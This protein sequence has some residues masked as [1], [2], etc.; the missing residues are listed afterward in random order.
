[1]RSNRWD[2]K[3]V[4]GDEAI[5]ASVS[6]SWYRHPDTLEELE[7]NTLYLL[8]DSESNRAVW[9]EN[10]EDH[11]AFVS[12]DG[13]KQERWYRHPDSI[14][15]SNEPAIYVS[16]SE[17][18]E[19]KK[20]LTIWHENP[21]RRCVF[22]S[23]DGEQV[24]WYRPPD[25]PEPNWPTVYVSEDSQGNPTIWHENPKHRG[26]FV[27]EDGE[28]VYD[29]E[30]KKFIQIYERRYKTSTWICRR[31]RLHGQFYFLSRFA[32]EAFEGSVLESDE[33]CDHGNHDR[34]NN[35]IGNLRRRHMLFQNNH[36]QPYRVSKETGVQGVRLVRGRS[37]KKY[38][39][40]SY[41][42]YT[43]DGPTYSIGRHKYF[44]VSTHGGEEKALEAAIDWR[45][46]THL[47]EGMNQESAEIR[48]RSKLNPVPDGCFSGGSPLGD[49]LGA[50]EGDVLGL[51]DASDD[52]LLEA[53]QQTHSNNDR[54]SADDSD[55]DNN[56]VNNSTEKGG[57]EENLTS[58]VTRAS[59][60]KS[61]A[62]VP[63]DDFIDCS[64]EDSDDDVDA[65]PWDE[66]KG[67][68]KRS[69]KPS[70][71]QQ[72]VNDASDDGLLEGLRLGTSLGLDYG[73]EYDEEI[74][75][76]PI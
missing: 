57:V 31:L 67:P 53:H 61:N 46:K 73:I 36:R 62:L 11:G 60:Q 74:L 65:I 35:E 23:E 43:P 50:E 7:P 19:S 18:S 41:S 34:T 42:V 45:K 48:A 27:S 29:R 16:K 20:K 3:E 9:H 30:R 75:M 37:N 22:V 69:T 56:D 54:D 70:T 47:S 76:V 71:R 2:S 32:L 59:G 25:M 51:D 14:L 72:K 24:R 26:V 1:L 6:T 64:N 21:K 58:F 13:S 68:A 17:D 38:F 8:E 28:Q 5:R 33:T 15:E 55:D 52:G 66:R 44:F 10:P 12:E 49:A 39:V 4:L 40:V 63:F